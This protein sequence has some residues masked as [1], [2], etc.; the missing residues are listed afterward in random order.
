MTLGVQVTRIAQVQ[1]N[2]AVTVAQSQTHIQKLNP[3]A[4][5]ESECAPSV[6]SAWLILQCPCFHWDAQQGLNRVLPSA[7]SHLTNT[8][9]HTHTQEKHLQAL[10]RKLPIP[11]FNV[12]R[13]SMTIGDV[14]QHTCL[15]QH[16]LW[17]NKLASA[18]LAV[19]AG[20]SPL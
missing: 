8:N 13:M 12:Q 2:T 3:R 1:N 4:T 5:D 15:I 9:A 10:K 7:G 11:Q 16:W 6:N 20:C 19:M 18:G 17:K 14:K